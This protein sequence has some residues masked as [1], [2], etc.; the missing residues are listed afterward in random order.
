MDWLERLRRAAFLVALPVVALLGGCTTTETIRDTFEIDI[1]NSAHGSVLDTQLKI[2]QER[3][4]EY[5]RRADLQYKIAAIHFQKEDFRTSAKHLRRAIY[6][7]PD[8]VRYHYDLGRVHLQMGELEEA[9]EAFREAVR[10]G[11][12]RR[13]SGLYAALGYTLCRLKRWDEAKT[14]FEI[15]TEIDVNDPTPYYFLGS[16]ADIQNDRQTAVES[17]RLYLE[18]GGRAFRRRAIEILGFHG[19]EVADDLDKFHEFELFD[20]TTSDLPDVGGR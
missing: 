8:H 4:A 20:E 16:I 7:N 14:Q 15:C 10:I 9:E 13:W 19:V 1:P 3:A 11:G 18:K 17:L 5:P 6:L 2:L 12:K